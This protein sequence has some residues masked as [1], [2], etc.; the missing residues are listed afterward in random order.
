MFNKR[1]SDSFAH[2]DSQKGGWTVF[3]TVQDEI[4]EP[5]LPLAA[6]VV[7][8]HPKQHLHALGACE[9]T[10]QNTGPKQTA[11]RLSFLR[12]Y[13]WCRFVHCLQR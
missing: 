8:A 3:R 5:D 11:A 4:V 9:C 6:R 13:P 1:W 7:G 2:N 10:K 12:I